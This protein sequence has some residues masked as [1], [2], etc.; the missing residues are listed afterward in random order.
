MSEEEGRLLGRHWLPVVIWMA[1]IFLFSSQPYSG[2][3]SESYLGDLNVPVRKCAH[4]F[5]YFVLFLLSARAFR[6]SP[7][8][9]CE[10]ANLLAVLLCIFYAA[11]DEWH[12]SFVPGRSSSIGD[13][14]VDLLGV[15]LAFGFTLFRKR[16]TYQKR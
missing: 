16:I 6:Q 10:H 15:A 12:Q 8:F 7:R 9:W 5:E 13:A 11:S 2:A 3:M 14:L 4:M 1:V